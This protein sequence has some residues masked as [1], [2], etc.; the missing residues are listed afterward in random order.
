MSE[1]WSSK[2][3]PETTDW[4]EKAKLPNTGVVASFHNG[5]I[6]ISTLLDPLNR[7]THAPSEPGVVVWRLLSPTRKTKVY[8]NAR[9]RDNRLKFDSTESHVL[10]GAVSRLE[11]MT[12]EP[13]PEAAQTFPDSRSRNYQIVKAGVDELTSSATPG[14]WKDLRLAC[15]ASVGPDLER[16][17]PGSHP[18]ASEQSTPSEYRPRR[19]SRA[20]TFLVYCTEW[21]SAHGGLSTFN[22]ELCTA[23]IQLGHD[24]YLRMVGPGVPS[25]RNRETVFFQ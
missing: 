17:T 25:R 14:N 7:P 1:D 18:A 16:R 8:V 5:N 13:H 11:L 22:R 24:V 4:L 9:F 10:D 2:L 12:S 20:G 6:L 19:S 21:E 15:V 23:L 3:D